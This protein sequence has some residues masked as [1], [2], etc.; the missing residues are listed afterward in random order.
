MQK[1]LLLQDP[2]AFVVKDDGATQ[3]GPQVG[4]LGRKGALV[5][6][7]GC[8]EGYG[9]FAGASVCRWP[10]VPSPPRL[11]VGSTKIKFQSTRLRRPFVIKVHRQQQVKHRYFH[12]FL[13]DWTLLLQRCSPYQHQICFE[14]SLN[15]VFTKEG[16]GMQVASHILHDDLLFAVLPTWTGVSNP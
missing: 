8:R 3:V 4:H 6:E 2:P 1:Q 12:M 7:P 15:D 5:C 10:S 13:V 9:P 14:D 11:D 16:Q